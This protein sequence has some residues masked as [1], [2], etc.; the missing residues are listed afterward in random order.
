MVKQSLTVAAESF[1]AKVERRA[2]GAKATHTRRSYERALKEFFEVVE[3]E[4]KIQADKTPAS[5]IQAESCGNRTRLCQRV[6]RRS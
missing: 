1:L 3:S 5:E 6:P 2:K 4:A